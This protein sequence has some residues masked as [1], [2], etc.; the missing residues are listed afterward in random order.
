M[1]LYGKRGCL[2]SPEQVAA[3]RHTTVTRAATAWDFLELEAGNQPLER[4]VSATTLAH[5]D[6]DGLRVRRHG[7]LHAQLREAA[8]DFF[9]QPAS[10]LAEGLDLLAAMLAE[11]DDH[12]RLRIS[13]D[14]FTNGNVRDC[15]DV[16]GRLL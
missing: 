10:A 14:T 16:H 8:V 6:D 11:I 1:P 12:G 4:L 2:P 7:A 15:G 13:S 9:G 5:D 3:A